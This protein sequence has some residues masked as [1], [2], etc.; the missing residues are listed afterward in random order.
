MR[1]GLLL[2]LLLLSVSSAFA[3]PSLVVERLNHDFGEI[4]QG[5]ESTNTFR[6]YN[7]GDQVLEV[8]RLRSSC[9]CTAALLTTRR[10]APGAMGELR[11]TFNSQGFRG[12]VQKVVTFETNDPKHP[13]VTFSLRGKVKAELYLQPERI[14]WGVVGKDAPLQVDLE[15]VN[16]STQ[17]ITLQAPKITSTGIVAELSALRI[18]PG[19]STILKV[20]AE[21]PEG[22]KRLAGYVLI[23]SDFP[24]LPQLKLPVSARLSQK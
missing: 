22:K 18:S 10:L 19:E 2:L 7:A 17:T 8:G 3:V 23:D 6:F 4:L 9:G 16:A 21:F 12:A 14:N 11:L 5:A 24:N 1:C 13:V 15:I 20:A